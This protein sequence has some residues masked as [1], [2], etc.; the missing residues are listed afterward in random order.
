MRPLAAFFITAILYISCS[1]H[2]GPRVIT[3]SFYY[4]ST[5]YTITGTDSGFLQQAG[6]KKM[7]VRFFDVG[8]SYSWEGGDIIP[9]GRLEHGQDFV[10]QVETVPVIFI[11]NECF[12][13]QRSD[14]DLNWLC[15]KMTTKLFRMAKNHGLPE[16]RIHEIQLDCDW[17][18]KTRD[19]YFRFLQLFKQQCKGKKLS[20]TLRLYQ[21]KYRKRSGIPPADRCM[22]MYY[23][24]SRLE[25]ATTKNY[26]LDNAVGKKYLTVTEPYPL[27]LDF[28]LPIYRQSVQ[29]STADSAFYG[30]EK[31]TVPD[32]AGKKILARN[33]KAGNIYVKDNDEAYSFYR[34]EYVTPANLREAAQLLTGAVNTD[35]F[36]VSFFHLDENLYKPI[37]HEVFNEVIGLLGNNSK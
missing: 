28:A 25:E 14:S 7:Y 4:W 6:C 18:D 32:T 19:N 16:E 11:E 20:V 31:V 24:M 33:P 30:L 10:Q 2:Q 17:T 8:L 5:H 36:S 15:S 26:I 21:Y 27:P 9:M 13:G 3:P 37:G 22:L 23:N 35:T 29:F 12:Q 1:S 34:Y